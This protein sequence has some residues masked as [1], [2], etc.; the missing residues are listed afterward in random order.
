MRYL[1]MKKDGIS[2]PLQYPS[3]TP[4]DTH[5]HTHTRAQAHTNTHNW[6]G[7]T[8]SLLEHSAQKS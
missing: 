6:S 7:N 2:S 5:T 1:I 3:P 4:S 8:K